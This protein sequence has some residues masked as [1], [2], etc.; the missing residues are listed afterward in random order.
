MSDLDK[1]GQ[2][3]DAVMASM[4]L[5]TKQ[6]AA[7]KAAIKTEGKSRRTSPSEVEAKYPHVI[8][9]T[10]RFD[11]SANKQKATI[12]CSMDGCSTKRDVF[13]SDLFQVRVCEEHKKAER[14]EA[15]DAQK[16]LLEAF[17]AKQ[18]EAKVQPPAPEAGEE[19]EEDA[20]VTE[21][22]GS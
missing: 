7:L 4:G 13:T 10:V 18:A 1:V 17:K 6:Q 9:G 21:E 8:K 2:D 5:D 14:K 11:A 16:A 3:I 12:T 20:T 15:R 22:A 19:I